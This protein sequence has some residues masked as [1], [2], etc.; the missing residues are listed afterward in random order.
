MSK[1]CLRY[2][3]YGKVVGLNWEAISPERPETA[4]IHTVKKSKPKKKKK[5]VI[6][7]VRKEGD[8]IRGHSQAEFAKPKKDGSGTYCS[9]CNRLR[10][11]DYRAKGK[12][13]EYRRKVGLVK[14]E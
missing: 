13:K 11:A 3:D 10:A 5:S 12:Q 4:F 9:E 14:S 7:V 8:C 6:P 1:D 2:N